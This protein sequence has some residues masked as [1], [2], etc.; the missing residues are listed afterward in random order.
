MLERIFYLSPI[1]PELLHAPQTVGVSELV[2]ALRNAVEAQ[3]GSQRHPLLD[4]LASGAFALSII[5]DLLTDAA[6][7]DPCCL[8]NH[9]QALPPPLFCNDVARFA[10]PLPICTLVSGPTLLVKSLGAGNG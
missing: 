5:S 3:K 9:I 7:R 4:T 8:I 1:K 10:R 6:N 2:C